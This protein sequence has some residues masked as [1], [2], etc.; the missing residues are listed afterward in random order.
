METPT[1]SG[2][3]HRAWSVLFEDRYGVGSGQRLIA[4]LEQ[5]CVTFARVAEEFGVTRECVR[6]WH[7]R[8]LPGAPSGHRRQQLCREHQN[9]L[10]AL[11]LY[12][13]VPSPEDGLPQEAILRS[14]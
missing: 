8:W 9:T 10:A 13:E 7:Q 3:A 1:E 2:S 6:Q 4:M 12:G 5:P 14:V 11:E